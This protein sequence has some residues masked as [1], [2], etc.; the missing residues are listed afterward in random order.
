MVCIGSFALAQ[1]V[2]CATPAPLARTN[3]ASWPQGTITI[4][5]NPTDFPTDEQRG[6]IQS[7][8]TTWQNTNP[9]SGVRFTF[10]T[11]T[12]PAPGSQLNTYYVN[13]G[14]TTTG[15]D[16][17]IGFSGSLN[18][19]GNIT[20]SAVT[21]LDSSITRLSTITNVML[22]E[23]GHTFG[24]DDCMDC[25]QGSTI[26]STYRNDCFCATY[27]CDQQVPFNGIPL[28]MSSTCSTK[29]LRGC[30]SSLR[31]RLPHAHANPRT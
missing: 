2:P 18:T 15:A 26:M 16:T 6:A 28:G 7:A 29:G 10:T 12:Q 19:T 22:H 14:T 3:G 27:S 21:I 1:E 30:G 25:V 17:N 9:N 13:R 31:V 20:E 4:I 23:I 11:G 8:F 5:I 24:L